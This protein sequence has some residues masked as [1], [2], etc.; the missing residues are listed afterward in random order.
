MIC[1]NIYRHFLQNIQ[2][3]TSVPWVSHQVTGRTNHSG[4]LKAK[5]NI[6]MGW[7]Q[8]T[9][10][11]LSWQPSRL[12]S[13]V[14]EHELFTK[15]SE[16]NETMRDSDLFPIFLKV[17]TQS[18]LLPYLCTTRTPKPLYNAQIGGRFIFIPLWACTY[19]SVP[20][21]PAPLSRCATLLR[22]PPLKK[23]TPKR[24]KSVKAGAQKRNKS[25]KTGVQKRN[26]SEKVGFKKRNKSYFLFPR[27]E[28]V[29]IL[30]WFSIIS[31]YFYRN[32][33]ACAQIYRVL[34][35]FPQKRKRQD[36]GFLRLSGEV[37]HIFSLKSV[38]RIHPR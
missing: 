31:T 19:P 3:L 6:K 17:P 12:N 9:S 37:V 1:L 4:A 25:A 32:T 30:H 13:L 21:W 38:E 26:K 33:Y 23:K 24:N 22:L 5:V 11:F 15:C 7:L 16:I 27:D 34:G 28:E 2:W 35:A 14:L 20:L 36:C 18:K 10:T 29:V 8:I